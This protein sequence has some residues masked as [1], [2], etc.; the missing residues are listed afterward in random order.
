LRRT[1]L[2]NLASAVGWFDKIIFAAPRP[3]ARQFQNYYSI[4][5]TLNGLA[6]D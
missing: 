2:S 6:A 4:E 5:R 1:R 3:L